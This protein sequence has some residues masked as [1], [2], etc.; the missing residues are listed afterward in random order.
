[1]P[2]KGNGPATA[3]HGAPGA[4]AASISTLV[5]SV[6]LVEAS[7][8]QTDPTPFAPTTNVPL[9]YAMRGF[10]HAPPVSRTTQSMPLEE[11]SNVPFA[12]AATK[13][14]SPCATA[15]RLL[16]VP[17]ERSSHGPESTEAK[18]V[19][20]VPTVTKVVSPNAASLSVWLGGSAAFVLK[21]A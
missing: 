2:P 18:I 14:P 9:P 6:P 12:P 3:G 21:A 10:D 20:L 4:T 1:M 8:V 5:Q 13:S 17:D 16:V 11:L 7:I 15:C 19:P